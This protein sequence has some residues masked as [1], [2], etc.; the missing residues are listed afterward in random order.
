VIAGGQIFAN[1]GSG[2]SALPR[3]MIN[4]DCFDYPNANIVARAKDLPFCDDSL[5]GIVSLSVLEYLS[6]PM[7][8]SSESLHVLKPGGVLMLF[9]PFMLGFH[10]SPDD[11]I[12]FTPAGQRLKLTGFDIEEMW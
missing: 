9:V 3:E 4:V 7:S 1:I 2:N 11:L 8:T 5:N 12:R 10:A 6:N